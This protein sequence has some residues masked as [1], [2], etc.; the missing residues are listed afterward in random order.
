MKKVSLANNFSG[1]LST[2]GD[3][4]TFGKNDRNQLGF[5]SPGNIVSGNQL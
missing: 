1:M 5:E 3:L 4:Y 2:D